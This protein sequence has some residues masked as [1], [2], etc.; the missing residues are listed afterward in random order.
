MWLWYKLI[1]VDTDPL[2]YTCELMWLWYKLIKVDTDPLS[3][4]C[5]LMWLWYKLIK[6]D[7]DPLS[8]TRVLVVNGIIR[9]PAGHFDIQQFSWR[10]LF[11]QNARWYWEADN[12]QV[13]D[14][15]RPVKP[16]A[17]IR[18]T[19]WNRNSNARADLSTFAYFSLCLSIC[20]C[21]C[22]ECLFSS[23]LLKPT[24]RRPRCIRK[25]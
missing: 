24:F 16:A 6:V 9:P 10:T 11:G 1:K 20:L 12:L 4:T 2:S 14:A 18:V 21:N 17:R 7:T 25:G 13:L 15:F 5:E 8:Y 23:S 22:F 3:Y 19:R